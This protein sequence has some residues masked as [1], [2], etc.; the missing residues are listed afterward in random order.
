MPYIRKNRRKHISEGDV[1]RNP[2]ELN[3]QITH[4]INNYLQTWSNLDYIGINEA[5]GVLECVKQEF[6]RRI[7]VPYENQKIEENGDVY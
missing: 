7:A 1:P 5:I 3:Y 2:G 4:A 6:Y